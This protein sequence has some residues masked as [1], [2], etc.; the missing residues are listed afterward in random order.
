[1]QSELM[2]R[3]CG[4]PILVNP[5]LSRSVFESMHW[6]CFIWR[7]SIPAILIFPATIPRVTSGA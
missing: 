6:L 2:C 1:M 3:R 7:S 4:R 5:S